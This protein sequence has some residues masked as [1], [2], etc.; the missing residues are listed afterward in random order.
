[1]TS[2]SIHLFGLPV[3]SPFH[4]LSR[5]SARKNG[6]MAENQKHYWSI[7]SF[8]YF[9]RASPIQIARCHVSRLMNALWLSPSFLISNLSLT[10]QE[11]MPIRETGL[12]DRLL[13]S[14]ALWLALTRERVWKRS[15]VLCHRDLRAVHEITGMRPALSL[16]RALSSF[17]WPARQNSPRFTRYLVGGES[18][19]KILMWDP[20][21]QV[22]YRKMSR[23]TKVD[24][25]KRWD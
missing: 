5:R 11:I 23:V 4:L 8:N 16:S 25:S 3:L 9:H 13:V 15:R 22:V 1:M 19:P 6:R 17:L 14:H 2:A 7:A 12:S 18:A 24:V 10:G 21:T 20:M